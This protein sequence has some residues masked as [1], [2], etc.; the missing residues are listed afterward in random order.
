MIKINDKEYFNYTYNV[1]WGNFETTNSSGKENGIS[2]FIT[3]NIADNLSIGIET[4]ISSEK[5]N[6]IENS[7]VVNLDKYITDII[8]EDENGWVSIVD[9][10]YSCILS[11]TMGN[12]FL[13]KFSVDFEEQ[14]KLNIIINSEVELV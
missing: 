12:I 7:E 14:E 2:P 4:M 9:S 13:I 6:S 3:F 1:S 11:R 5:L 8:Y 10:K